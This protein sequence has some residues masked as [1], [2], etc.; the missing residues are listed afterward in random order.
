[1]Q[2]GTAERFVVCPE[3]FLKGLK[4]RIYN[5]TTNFSGKV[6]RIR[7]R[8]NKVKIFAEENTL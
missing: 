8:S 6:Q 1:M 2:W 7:K 3:F 4:N 5:L